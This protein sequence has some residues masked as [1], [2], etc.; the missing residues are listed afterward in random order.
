MN[1]IVSLIGSPFIAAIIFIIGAMAGLFIFYK[2]EMAIEIQRRFYAN[3]NWRIEP[4][5]MSKEISATRL[6]GLFLF[7]CSL[8]ASIFYYFK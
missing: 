5:S 2:P 3:I 4:I 7:I 6:M 8:I 1:P